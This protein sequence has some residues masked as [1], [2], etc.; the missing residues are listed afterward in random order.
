MIEGG[1]AVDA[2][3][4]VTFCIGV[5][6]PHNAGIGGA[7]LMTIYIPR[8]RT[9]VSLNAREAAPGAATENMFNGD[10]NLSQKGPLAVAVP[11][12]VAGSWAVHQ[13]Y[14]LLPWSR[15]VRPS[16]DI[17]QNGIT[18]TKSLATALADK[19]AAIKAEP[20]MRYIKFV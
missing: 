4:A 6:L 18:V 11:G 12:E 5:M 8:T 7:S 15:L 14:G 13:T 1:N 2:A 17:A 20:S 19:A 3:V 16:A 9:A 10:A